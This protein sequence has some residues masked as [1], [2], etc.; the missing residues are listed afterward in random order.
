[1]KGAA[2]HRP[3]WK[4]TILTTD[5]ELMTW[6]KNGDL[7]KVAVLYERY[8]KVLYG[9]FFKTT[10]D[11]QASEDLVHTVFFKII[12]YRMRFRAE[13]GTFSAWMFGIAHNANIDYYRSLANSRT[14]TRAE[15]ANIRGDCDPD[16]DLVKKE[17]SHR[18]KEALACLTEA[19]REVLILSRYQDLKYE[20]IADILKCRVGTVKARVFRAVEKLRRVYGRMEER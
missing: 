9:F 13:A 12:K 16:E 5:N 3:A 2:L 10:L 15:E 19:Q 17:K 18:I 6:V 20:E 8:N 4:E 7:D 11:A 1:M 14:E